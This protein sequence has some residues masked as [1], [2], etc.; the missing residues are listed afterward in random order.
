MV[1]IQPGIS[2]SPMTGTPAKPGIYVRFRN[3]IAD[4]EDP[5]IV[6]RLM[7]HELMGRDY[8][9][10]EEGAKDPYA[11]NRD[12]IEPAHVITEIK[13]GHV[14]SKKTSPRKVKLTPEMKKLV[15]ELA[16]EK[17]KEI[18]PELIDAAIAKAM[19]AKTEIA[20]EDG[21]TK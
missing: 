17:A 15:N 1:V 4:V 3:G 18:M 16:M 8:V 20:K 10:M 12:E 7:S 9:A 14:E 11:E 13:Y 19:A 6:T 2:A 5:E 21:K